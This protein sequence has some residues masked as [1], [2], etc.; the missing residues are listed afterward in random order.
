MLERNDNKD[1]M[2]KEKGLKDKR[3]KQGLQK[4]RSEECDDA[5]KLE[6]V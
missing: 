6:K 1:R 3:E 5:D 2:Q 4:V